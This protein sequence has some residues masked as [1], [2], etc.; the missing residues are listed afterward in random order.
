MRPGSEYPEAQNRPMASSFLSDPDL[1]RGLQRRDREALACVYR[2]YHAAVYNLCARILNDREEAK[3]VTQDVF[4]TALDRP[5]ADV[6]DVR[7]RPWLFR[8]ATNACLNRIRGRRRSE[9]MEAEAFAAG[10]DPYEQA[11]LATLVG[12]S[13]AALNERYRAALVLKDL[14]GLDT[15]ELAEVLEVSRPAADVLVHRARA[16]FRRAFA[17][18]A[19]GDAVA[20]ANL[21]QALP[22]LP[23]PAVLQ[24]LPAAAP[25]GPAMPAALDPSAATT[26]A[27]APAGPAIAAAGSGAAA[28]VPSGG[29]LA[30]LGASLGA[31]AAVVA[32]GAALLAGGGTAAGKLSGDDRRVPAGKAATPSV[33]HHGD[34]GGQHE[35]SWIGERHRLRHGLAG[36]LAGHE[37]T[38]AARHEPDPHAASRAHDSAG[39]APDQSSD[40]V[41]TVTPDATVH[42]PE[43][44]TGTTDTNGSHEGEK[45]G[46]H[47]ASRGL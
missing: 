35:G 11:H 21:A 45:D 9:P 5:P 24:T 23:V 37:E 2:E 31:K 1:V 32:A 44:S 4:L 7:L 8:V 3:D 47:A 12:T 26:A 18:T 38:H 13:L 19:G 28:G 36:H 43:P 30:H 14:H 46:D 16:A 27:V 42:E 22:V 40:H 6:A 33:S 20:P 29:L 10:G 39:G 25:P 34:A 41:D 17:A 15:R